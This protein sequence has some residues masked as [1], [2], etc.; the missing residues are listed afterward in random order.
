MSAAEGRDV[1]LGEQQAIVARRLPRRAMPATAADALVRYRELVFVAAVTGIALF[2]RTYDL[3]SYPPGFHGD[4]GLVG[5]EAQR[6]LRD[7]WIGPYVPSALGM[8]AGPIYFVAV[9]F[10]VFGTSAHSVRL[11]MALLGTLSV[12]IA[13]V[14]F[15]TM[16]GYRV[17]VLATIFLAFSALDIHFS[18]V[19]FMPIAQ[20]IIEVAVLGPLFMA[21]RTRR[22]Y[23]F[24][25]AGVLTGFGVFSYSPYPVFVAAVAVFLVWFGLRAYGRKALHLFVRDMAIFWGA[26]YAGGFSM[27]QYARTT[28]GFLNHARTQSITSTP[29]WKQA[30]LLHRGQIVWFHAKD[31]L[32]T[33]TTRPKFD[34]VDATGVGRMFDNL[35]LF[36]IAAGIVIA[37]LNWRKLP[38]AFGLIMLVVMPFGAI[39]TIGAEFRRAIGL[40]PVIVVL[41]A[42][43]L[44]RIWRW[45]DDSGRVQRQAGYAIIG[46]AVAFVC[47]YNV[48]YYFG[49]LASSSQAHWVY[50]DELASASR[51][52][53]NAQP[54]Y[55]YFYSARWSYDYPTRTFLAPDIPGEDRSKE[56]STLDAS[57]D[58]DPSRGG[59]F[60]FIGDYMKLLP[61]VEARYP[62]GTAY[63]GRGSDG[64]Q[65]F[66]A[67]QLQPAAPAATRP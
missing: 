37:V 65:L 21:V 6:V 13:Y 16:F 55:V 54:P 17:A 12:P 24:L 41:M 52:V 45:A 56:F 8:A 31:W 61:A 19:G 20:P 22:W 60:V 59:M 48:H 30:D 67:Y 44:E 4:E 9:V 2:L 33:V 23:W 49:T 35:T 15:R 7:G 51:Y 46:A 32:F 40:L 58:V 28:P 62:G 14:A 47:F 50:V 25:A 42:L 5:L 53:E 63:T 26:F 64:Q 27:L 36:L 3:M 10:K 11:S 34:G 39:M 38:Y 43:P 57:I 66:A 18:R 29:Q 1:V